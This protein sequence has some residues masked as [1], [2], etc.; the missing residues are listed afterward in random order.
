[1]LLPVDTCNFTVE[2]QQAFIPMKKNSS[3]YIFFSILLIFADG[4]KKEDTV[5]NSA[6]Q[7]IVQGNYTLKVQANHHWWSVSNLPVYLKKNATEWP[8]TDST[9]YEFKTTT[10]ANGR[11]TFDHLFQGNYYLYAHG[12]DAFFGM[13]VIGYGPVQVNS[14]TAVNNEVSFTLNVSE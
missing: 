9:L 12:F 11:C 4:C 5:K 8:G 7:V 1:L 10:D 3:W 2:R 13:N 14:T 6:G